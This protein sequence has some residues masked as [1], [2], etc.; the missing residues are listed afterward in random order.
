MHGIVIM[1][2]LYSPVFFGI[3]LILAHTALAQ[4]VQTNDLEEGRR[5]EVN[6]LAVMED[7]VLAGTNN[8]V[9]RKKAAC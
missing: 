8:G 1:E 4:W 5:G 3:S 2:I 6:C 9:F 7:T